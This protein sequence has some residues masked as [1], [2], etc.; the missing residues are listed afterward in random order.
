M[1]APA[2]VEPLPKNASF[3][4][5]VMSYKRVALALLS[6]CFMWDL[7]Y[8]QASG[9]LS[10]TKQLAM[11]KYGKDPNYLEYITTVPLI[12]PQIFRF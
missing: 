4:T 6:P 12:F 11:S 5:K 2:L 1:N 10:N 3:W 7:F 9:H 8:G